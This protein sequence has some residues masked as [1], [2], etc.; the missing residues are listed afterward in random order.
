MGGR[1]GN[2]P[3]ELTSFIGRSRELAGVQRRLADTR[4]VTLVGVGG[5]G[6][7]RLALRAAAGL[8]RTF[9]AGVWLVELD[10]VQDDG[11]VAPAVARALGVR[12]QAGMSS[13]MAVR[14]FLAQ[15]R[16]LLILDN[17]EHV[18]CGVTKLVDA[19]LRDTGEVRILAT[20]R[21]R[22]GLDGERAYPVLPLA[23]PPPGRPLRLVESAGYEAVALFAERAQ[24]LVAGF[25]LTEAQQ[26]A[27]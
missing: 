13:E 2:L 26:D 25:E 22:L 11:Q 10:Q 14:E 17:C 9:D 16:R 6:K 3:A 27:V 8:R 18:A 24:A 1:A 19:L 15:R 5:V 23:V 20:S 7:T 12:E 21:Q 4:L